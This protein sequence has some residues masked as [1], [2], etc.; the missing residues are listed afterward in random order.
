[1]NTKSWL[2]TLT[3][4]IIPVLTILKGMINNQPLTDQE[5]EI[6]KYFLVTFLGTGTIGMVNARYKK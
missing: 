2:V 6:I 5:L 3:P 1:M 4:L